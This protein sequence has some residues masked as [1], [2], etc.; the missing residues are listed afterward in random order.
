MSRMSRRHFLGLGA[1]AAGP[2]SLSGAAERVYGQTG[3]APIVIGVVLPLS[4]PYADQGSG[5]AKGIQFCAEQINARGGLLGRPIDVLVE[6]TQLKPQVAV[7]KATKLISQD[8]VNFLMGEI[9]GASTLAL[10]EVV[11]R[12]KIVM[13]TPYSSP[14]AVT[15]ARG[16][17]FQFRT[18]SNTWIQ[19]SIAADYMTKNVGKRWGVMAADYA[20]GQDY[21]RH[22]RT[23][24]TR[25]GGHI[26]S[27]AF[28]PLGT[29]DF[30]SF[31]AKAAA[32]D[33]DVLW[34][35]EY[36]RDA[37]V[38]L[39]Q[40]TS[41]GLKK[42]MAL[43]L[44]VANTEQ[45][46]GMQPGVFD[47]TYA[48]VTWYPN[49]PGEATRSFV[50]AYHDKHGDYSEAAGV[51]YIGAQVLFQAITN[52]G[53]VD[54]DAVIK[55]FEDTTFETI[56]G[57]LRIRGY[58]HQAVQSYYLGKGVPPKNSGIPLYEPAKWYE[59]DQVEKDFMPPADPTLHPVRWRQ[60]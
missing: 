13:C 24:V 46:K 40:A 51:H 16:T 7:V 45:V 34:M 38:A 4:G 60:S 5:G 18:Y 14:E 15:G 36:G 58:D 49:W 1:A 3:K 23:F 9:S 41:M 22:L 12:A 33:P 43:G 32:G 48:L 42:K 28:P 53:S 10:L 55:A 19:A 44:G 27:E 11:E 54:A 39:N 59:A 52:A 26:V 6:D 35:V 56:K 31:L 37:A 25:A 2:L 17:R 20:Y 21:A 8:N 30:A 29:T 50:K 57:K 47:G